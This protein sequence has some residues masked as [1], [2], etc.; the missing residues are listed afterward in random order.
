M[1]D[2]VSKSDQ[3]PNLDS[4]VDEKAEDDPQGPQLRATAAA[5]II[6]KSP[7]HWVDQEGLDEISGISNRAVWNVVSD[8]SDRQ[9]WKNRTPKL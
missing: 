5:T 9:R 2:N 3:E 4:P 8:A 1:S 7:V 6:G